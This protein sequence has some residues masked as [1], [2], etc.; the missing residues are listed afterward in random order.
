MLC[1]GVRFALCDGPFADFRKL[2]AS[3]LAVVGSYVRL[4]PEAKILVKE[5]VDKI[6]SLNRDNASLEVS[7]EQARQSIKTLAEKTCELE[8][9]LKNNKDWYKGRDDLVE[10]TKRFLGKVS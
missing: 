9:K 5:V 8:G 2:I 3:D 10:G 1:K 6:E 4:E 7:V